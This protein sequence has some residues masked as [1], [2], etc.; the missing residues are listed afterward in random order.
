MHHTGPYADIKGDV[1][2]FTMSA[3]SSWSLEVLQLPVPDI[4]FF[5]FLFK[6]RILTKDQLNIFAGQA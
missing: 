5:Y 1:I 4:F 2:I 3:A 6:T